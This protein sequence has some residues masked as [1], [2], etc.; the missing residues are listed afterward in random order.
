M[1]TAQPQKA[2]LQYSK[3]LSLLSS[4]AKPTKPACVWSKNPRPWPKHTDEH[5]LNPSHTRYTYSLA[6][7]QLQ[8]HALS[9]YLHQLRLC[10]CCCYLIVT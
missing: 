2:A 10:G 6:C 7:L 9:T 8:E 5:S 1:S 4:A 3:W